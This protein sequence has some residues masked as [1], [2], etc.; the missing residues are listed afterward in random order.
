M[1]IHPRSPRELVVAGIKCGLAIVNL[2][3]GTVVELVENECADVIIMKRH[4]RYLICGSSHGEIR[5]HDA[6]EPTCPAIHRL[7]AFTSTI[8]DLVVCGN[9]ILACGYHQRYG[10]FALEAMVKVFDARTLRPT[11][12]MA[13]GDGPAFLRS[14]PKMT[15]CALILSHSGQMQTVDVG[16]TTDL[17]LRQLSTMAYITHFDLSP[18][19]DAMVFCDAD[20]NVHL[21]G[22]AHQTEIRFTDFSNQTVFA[23]FQAPIPDIDLWADVPLHS[24][25][26]P[27]YREELFSSW[28]A[29]M[30]FEVGKP[31]PKIDPDILANLKVIDD[32]GYAP[33]NRRRRRNL[34]EPRTQRNA[35]DTPRFRSEKAKAIASGED[36]SELLSDNI[37]ED[38]GKISLGTTNIPNYYKKMEIKYSKFGI[39]D[40]DF[41]YY[42]NTPFAGL[43]TSFANS[44]C[45]AILQLY[46]F[47]HPLNRTST[48]HA[49]GN[50]IQDNCLLCE[51]GYLFGMLYDAKGQNCQASNFH[52]SLASNKE[53]LNLGLVLPDST[54][55][56]PIPWANLTQSFNRFLLETLVRDSL[57][58]KAKD[59]DP[60]SRS[61]ELDSI[62]GIFSKIISKCACGFESVKPGMSVVTDLAYVKP[63]VSRK[64]NQ[65]TQFST[66]LRMSI[67]REGH[68]R[69]WC[70]ACRQYQPANIRRV[71]QSLPAVIN[72]NA[73]V[74][75][76]EQWRHWTGKTWPP[77][78]IGV[79][80]VNGKI[81]IVQGRDL[82]KRNVD[83]KIYH[84]V[85]RGLTC[86]IRFDEQVAHMVT[87]VKLQDETEPKWLLFNDF[88]V[89]SVSEEE[90]LTFAAPWK[91]PS[92]LSYERLQDFSTPLHRSVGK[93]DTWIL[94]SK[95]TLSSHSQ[96]PDNF[97]LL[98]RDEPLGPG[99]L[100][101]IDAEFV[102]LQKEEMEVRSD[103]TKH[104][105]QPRRSALARVSVLR[106]DGDKEGLPFIDDY[107][108]TTEHIADYLTE[109]SGIHEGDLDPHSSKHY[110]VPQK[111]AYKKL[112][113]LVRLGCKFIGHGL[114]SDFRIINLAI[115]KEQ[116][117][118][119]VDLFY[120]PERQRKLSLKF[121]AW[122]FLEEQIQLD[123]HD[124]IEDARTA[125]LLYRKY[126]EFE[127]QGVVD[128]KLRELYE[129][130]RALNFKPPGSG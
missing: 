20:N 130:G 75:N 80:L 113:V 84:Y 94:Y 119:T 27:Y 109:F 10:N 70:Q 83:T 23:D 49:A 74:Q 43:E 60:Y 103:G 122:Y 21:L 50:C 76:S 127:A 55:Q 108:A 56:P 34:A 3:K 32:I 19:G 99:T 13:F 68:V 128:L 28:P 40:F 67:H 106:G 62:I 26:M 47:S 77:T 97:A 85:L 25:G 102:A 7:R 79:S 72:I 61:S 9:S 100:V 82:E 64:D 8:S 53:A 89:K 111:H 48:A 91:I 38:M 101:A 90:A 71:I 16:N 37:F 33:F 112:H 2:E 46:N 5:I 96:R 45:N 52:K 11:I 107:I 1:T 22:V 124:S 59:D 88:L 110:I 116:V 73:M 58:S 18:S 14:H 39:E 15:T 120:I 6:L 36:I 92:V 12:P 66:I 98:S 86:E 44:Y 29:T 95:F 30:L 65:T 54:A 69:D 115:P 105:I 4:G 93:L 17:R 78:R 35:L 81:Q 31:A 104:T 123:E 114:K 41:D 117:I 129:E 118:D 42:N 51:L 125:L 87:F 24:V 57:A 121:L 126:L 63:I